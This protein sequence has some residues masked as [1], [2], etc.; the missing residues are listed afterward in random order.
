MTIDLSI[1]IQSTRIQKQI[2]LSVFVFSDSLVVSASQDAGGYAISHQNNLEL[3]SGLVE[4]FFI[5]LWCGRSVGKAG[6]RSRDY[7]NFSA[8]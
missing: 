2:P 1:I 5:C 7:Q 4:L 6:K 8:G 3:H